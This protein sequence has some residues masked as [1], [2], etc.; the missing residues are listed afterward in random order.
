MAQALVGIGGIPRNISEIYVGIDG[1]LRAVTEV[2]A[3]LNNT[4]KLVW[5]GNKYKGVMFCTKGIGVSFTGLSTIDYVN[6]TYAESSTGKTLPPCKH[7]T[8]CNNSFY[9]NIYKSSKHCLGKVDPETMA[10]TL[11]ISSALSGWS[12]EECPIGTCGH[13]LFGHGPTNEVWHGNTNYI[14]RE[15][16]PKTLAVVQNLKLNGSFPFGDCYLLGAFGGRPDAL[17]FQLR[18]ED[19]EGYSDGLALMLYYFDT[20]LVSTY[21]R[22]TD[23]APIGCDATPNGDI[24]T[25]YQN[26]GIE[27]NKVKVSYTNYGRMAVMK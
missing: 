18:L 26:Q 20:G 27:K 24:Y 17:I 2:Y 9:F 19:G 7:F 3:G 1:A 15:Y 10:V 13:R 14:A 25:V 22:L 11:E 23:S 16:N 5:S 8:C 12:N 4:P 21:K 6:S